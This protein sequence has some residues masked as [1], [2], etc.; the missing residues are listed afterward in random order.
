[1]A[2]QG[3]TGP[4]H[5]LHPRVPVAASHHGGKASDDHGKR[6]APGSMFDCY[7]TV[8]LAFS[9]GAAV[10]ALLGGGSL[11]RTVPPWPPCFADPRPAGMLRPR[12]PTA[13]LLQ[14]F[15]L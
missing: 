8:L 13:P 2:C 7:V 9:L 5:Q 4:A 15:R 1:M 14:V 11:V 3:L 10:W 6:D 12:A